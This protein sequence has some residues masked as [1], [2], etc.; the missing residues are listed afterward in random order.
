MSITM[1]LATLEF[2]PSAART[3]FAELEHWLSSHAAAAHKLHVI[4]TEEERRGR[5]ILR[6]MLQAHINSRGDGDVGDQLTVLPIG[7]Q[8]PIA[9]RHKRLRS[10]GYVSLFGAVCVT[11]ME[12]SA[13]GQRNL[14][15][16]DASLG[17]P[18]RSYSYQIQRRLVK[19]AVKG[20]FDEA[21]E[22]LA[23]GTAVSVPKRTAQQIVLDASVDFESFY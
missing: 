13:P 23:D 22:E 21:T 15:P 20:P 7:S 8:Q 18:A 14:Y 11:R 19:A 12:Y 3:A 1:N 16:L 6:L 5:E 17:L 10:R 2:N 9:Y 4:E